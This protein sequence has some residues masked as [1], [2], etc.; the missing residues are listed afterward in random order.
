MPFV[1]VTAYC[2]T[3]FEAPSGAAEF[4]PRREPWVTS[5]APFPSPLP[6]AGEGEQKG[7]GD[8]FSQGSRPGLNSAAPDGASATY[9][10]NHWDR[11]LATKATA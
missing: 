8:R 7:V 11:R 10:T 1:E 5:A 9:T 2:N 3:D 4:S 6:R